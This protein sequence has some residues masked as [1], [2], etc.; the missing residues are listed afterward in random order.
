MLT[1]RTVIRLA[2]EATYGT[3]PA[4]GS[5]DELL[6]W[7][8]EPDIKGEILE[9][10][11]LRDCLSPIGPVI[12]LK[13]VGLNFKTELKSGGV[14]SAAMTVPEADLLLV[15]CGFATA[16]HA[17][18]SPIVYSLKSAEGDIKSLSFLVY[19]DGNMHKI[20]GARGSVKIT[21]EAGKY[22][23]MEWAFSGLYNAVAA[24]TMPDLSMVDCAKPPIIYASAFQ[25]AGFSPVCNSLS[26]DLANDIVRRD[27][28]NSATGVREFRITGRKPKM[29]FNA[30]A[31]IEATN[32]FWG[33]WVGNVIDTYGIVVGST[34]GHGFEVQIKGYFQYDKNKYGDQDGVS[35]YECSAML[36]S[37]DVNSNNDE[38]SVT[39]GKT[40]V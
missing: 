20:C 1:R 12:G 17:G 4:I 29:E 5:F 6:A 24:A 3:D 2:L 31:C 28:L 25:I 38:I 34:A 33:D 37:S 13:E 27:D 35:Q 32:P 21:M 9:R 36:V 11:I 15:G 7:D 18:T 19:K 23:I 22:G 26:I 10:S 8:V 39:F 16:A 40:A 30:D 14:G